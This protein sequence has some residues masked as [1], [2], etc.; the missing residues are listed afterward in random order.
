MSNRSVIKNW[1][2]DFCT[3]VVVTTASA[4]VEEICLKNGMLLHELLR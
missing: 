4:A 2:D 3:P 1:L